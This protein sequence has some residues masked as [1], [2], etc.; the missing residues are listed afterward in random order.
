MTLLDQITSSVPQNPPD[1]WFYF[2]LSVVLFV[3]I[4]LIVYKLFR[5]LVERLDRREENTERYFNKIAE[6][7]S[8]LEKITAR[9]DLEIENLKS[10]LH[11]RGKK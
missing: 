2:G 11:S 1:G 10:G 8:A 4:L 6:A 5:W 7:I 3:A 9:H